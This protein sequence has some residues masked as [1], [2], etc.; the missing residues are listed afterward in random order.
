MTSLAHVKKGAFGSVAGV[1][2]S[3]V[4]PSPGSS[5]DALK[6]AKY[7]A[8]IG[9]VNEP[10]QVSAQYQEITN[11]AADAPMEERLY[12]ALAMAK[13]LTGQVAMHLDSDW[14]E[15]LFLTLDHLLDSE[16]W[17]DED[18]P[19]GPASFSTFLRAIL[20]LRPSRRPGLGVT[21]QGNL[22]GAWT[23][24]R[25]RVTLEFLETDKVKWSLSCFIDEEQERAVGT[26]PVS[27]L[28]EVLAPYNPARWFDVNYLPT[29]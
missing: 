12:D 5:P 20:F 25:D 9:A 21:D 15:R 7:L 6:I 24:D 17:H 14:R 13:I 28:S 19:F 11:R 3:A 1:R 26:N 22:I 4:A 10:D 27:R 8:G 29:T 23:N 2:N 18:N 16:E